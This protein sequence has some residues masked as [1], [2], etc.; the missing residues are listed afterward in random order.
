M[1]SNRFH[2]NLESN[3]SQ[4]SNNRFQ[5]NFLLVNLD[6]KMKSNGRAILILFSLVATAVLIFLAEKK[7]L[8]VE[9]RGSALS[10]YEGKIKWADKIILLVEDFEGIGPGDSALKSA[11]FFTFGSA[12]ISVDT[13][14]T[15][16]NAISLK[17]SLKVEW[18]ST[19]N[20]GGWGKGLGI[21]VDLDPN[22][23]YLNFRAYFPASNGNDEK[24]KIVLQEDDLND[25]L[26]DPATDDEW[27]YIADIKAKDQWQI[28]SIPLK[29]FVDANEGGDGILNITRK[30][31]LHNIA[32][33]FNQPE[34][35]TR[36]H[37]W[38]FDFLF[39]SKGVITQ[40]DIDNN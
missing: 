38:Y 1:K 33:A 9:T 31:G 21:N 3:Y 2:S 19:I 12:K 40:Q 4:L 14:Q 24:I 5:K 26:W 15:D 17:S 18:D 22:T 11:A 36:H 13:A 34:K 39:F 16:G 35:Y 20:Y 29:N 25:G 7:F 37:Q 6:N 28:I 23:D 10:H 8:T 30:G 27:N 32:F